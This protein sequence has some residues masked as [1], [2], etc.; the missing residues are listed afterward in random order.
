M[1]SGPGALNHTAQSHPA[2][3][4][5]RQCCLVS[6]NFFLLHPAALSACFSV[7]QK[8]EI[9]ISVYP[10]SLMEIGFMRSVDLTHLTL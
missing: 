10:V 4:G 3:R 7:I 1:P 9:T 5:R 8:I 6:G 2:L